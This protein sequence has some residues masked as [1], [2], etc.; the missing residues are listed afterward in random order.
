[1][2]EL[3]LKEKGEEFSVRTL[4]VKEGSIV[5]R[6]LALSTAFV[7]VVAFWAVGQETKDS[8]KA[9]ATRKKLQQKLS[10]DYDETPLREVKD[11]LNEQVKGIGVRLDTKGGVSANI[12]ITFKAKNMTLA[13]IFDGLFKKNGLGYVV[14]SEPGAYDG[15][16]LI[17]Q[18]KQR[19][20]E[21]GQEPAKAA[22]KEKDATDDEKP[23]EKTKTK[24]KTATKDKT[25]DKDTPPDDGE[26]AE[27]DA[28]RKLDFAKAFVKDG[29]KAKAKERL[30][31]IV[32]KYPKTKAAEEAKELLKKLDK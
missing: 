3:F 7:F 14:I 20:Y 23:A 31:E 2:V 1:M 11:D 29:K 32:D 24:G 10:V 25:A 18:G 13:E 22:V 15:T 6:F 27:K 28:A 21:T 30:Q 17:K 16:I 4:A 19:G 12:K 9:A 26:K 8:P 5:R